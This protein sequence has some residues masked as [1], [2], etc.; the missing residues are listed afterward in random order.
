MSAVF[1]P[2]CNTAWF[3]CHDTMNI[4][5]ARRWWPTATKTTNNSIGMSC[6]AHN[7]QTGE[8]TWQRC[9]P[10]R[11]YPSV[12]HSRTCVASQAGDMFGSRPRREAGSKHETGEERCSRLR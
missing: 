8:H 2:A 10:S 7:T 11:A 3:S 9:V 4:I 6:F 5:Y 12:C 1:G